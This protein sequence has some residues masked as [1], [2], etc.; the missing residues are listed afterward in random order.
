MK[1][2]LLTTTST[3][4]ALNLDY[5]ETAKGCTQ[6]TRIY[7]LN[8]SSIDS[9]VRTYLSFFKEINSLESNSLACNKILI[10]KLWISWDTIFFKT[11]LTNTKYLIFNCIRQIPSKLFGGITCDTLFL[12]ITVQ[13]LKKP[14]SFRMSTLLGSKPKTLRY[15]IRPLHS[16]LCINVLH[17][18]L[19][20]NTYNKE[21]PTPRRV[22]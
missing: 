22:L 4:R 13:F 10:Y 5:N 16:C 17:P 21:L 3:S 11:N 18:P 2:L 6:F 1:V 12:R 14:G 15:N 9:E 19:I 7:N 8:P 20:D